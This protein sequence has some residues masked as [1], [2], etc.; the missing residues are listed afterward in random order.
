MPWI[1][2]SLSQLSIGLCP[3]F[4]HISCLQSV[5]ISFYQF[6]P[7]SGPL[8]MQSSSHTMTCMSGN[9]YGQCIILCSDVQLNGGNEQR[10]ATV[11]SCQST[12]IMKVN[13]NYMRQDKLDINV[14]DCP[15]TLS[16]IQYMI[17]CGG[18]TVV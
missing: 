17:W 15:F 1:S 14:S 6:L 11:F 4:S 18:R 3:H 2:I 7:N 8:A 12:R 16:I 10:N 13:G 9:A 5:Y